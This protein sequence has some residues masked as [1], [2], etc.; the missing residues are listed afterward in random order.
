VLRRD[1]N[2]PFHYTPF[3]PR[4]PE[5]RQESGGSLAGRLTP[6]VRVNVYQ[7]CRLGEL[8][9]VAGAEIEKTCLG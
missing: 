1:A 3:H 5:R 9:Y 2:S 4:A 8:S 7:M 6:D